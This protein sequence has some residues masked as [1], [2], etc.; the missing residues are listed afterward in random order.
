MPSC[1]HL[2]KSNRDG[3]RELTF[4]VEIDHLISHI[5]D[6][7]VQEFFSFDEL[8]NKLISDVIEHTNLLLTFISYGYSYLRAARNSEFYDMVTDIDYGTHH[9]L[10][11]LKDYVLENA[12][13][14][15]TGYL[16]YALL[17]ETDIED[18]ID[19]PNFKL[20]DIHYSF[21]TFSYQRSNRVVDIINKYYQDKI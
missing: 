9:S 3:T 1:I 12:C 19:K 14:R 11:I 13:A 21:V 10:D 20:I 6:Q 17:S 2:F 8:K 7:L 4:L 16:A 18:Y 5:Y 15:F